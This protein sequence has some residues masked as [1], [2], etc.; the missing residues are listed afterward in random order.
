VLEAPADIFSLSYSPYNSDLL[1]GGCYNGQV[2]CWEVGAPGSRARERSQANDADDDDREKVEETLLPSFASSIERSHRRCVNDIKWIPPAWDMEVDS[3][4]RLK[5][6]KAEN[7]TKPHQFVSIASDGQ[8]LF[9]D[10]E[11]K[12]NKAGELV[13]QPVYRIGLSAIEGGG[14]LG[15][16]QICLPTPDSPSCSFL[17]TSEEGE[18]ISYKWTAGSGEESGVS[19]VGNALP[20]CSACVALERSPFFPDVLLVVGDWTFSVF[21]VGVWEPL[22]CSN[23]ASY[24][25]T[26]GRWSPTRPGVVVIGKSDGSLDVWDLVDRSHEPNMSVNVSS[27]AVTS[28]EFGKPDKSGRQLLA[29]GDDLGALHILEMPRTLR[30]STPNEAAVVS[31]FID[32]EVQR[33]EYITSRLVLRAEELTAKQA[34]LEEEAKRAADAA[35]RERAA[36][37]ARAAAEEAGEAVDAS[38]SLADAEKLK[39]LQSA[40]AEYQKLEAKFRKELGLPEPPKA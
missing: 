20:H 21:K 29:V 32:R 39:Q 19:V 16:C 7:E 26:A 15:G 28:I 22:L 34:E 36:L 23:N 2:L 25:L 5:A 40:E 14:E 11:M 6:K 35:E 9:W 4:G 31:S 38:E 37:A 27:A 8:V 12:E 33:V 30:R 24:L 18:L 1:F 10:S 13:W 3:R 17:V